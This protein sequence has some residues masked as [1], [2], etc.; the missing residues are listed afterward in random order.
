MIWCIGLKFGDV[1]FCSFCGVL[2]KC[3]VVGLKIYVWYGMF[4]LVFIDCVSIKLG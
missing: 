2:V 3:C 4:G 1:M